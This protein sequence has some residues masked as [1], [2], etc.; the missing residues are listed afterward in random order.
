M[1]RVGGLSYAIDVGAP[2]GRRISDMTLLRT[3]KPIDPAASYVVSGWA[4]VNEGTQG[5][6][7]SDVV[8]AYLRATRTVRVEE[9]RHV[10]VKGADPRGVMG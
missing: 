6:A 3:G 10:T 2:M 4:S 9:N 7:V 8:S 1:V 5:P